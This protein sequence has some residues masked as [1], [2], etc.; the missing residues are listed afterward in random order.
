ML[1]FGLQHA[2]ADHQLGYLALG[3][4][5]ANRPEVRIELQPTSSTTTTTGP[6]TSTTMATTTTTMATTTTTTGPTPTTIPIAIDTYA[7]GASANSN[8]GTDTLLH[9]RRSATV[10]ENRVAY[11]RL[12]T[13]GVPEQ[14]RSN[15]PGCGSCA[16]TPPAPRRWSSSWP[17]R[18]PRGARPRS[19]EIPAPRRG[20]AR[21]L[22]GDLDG[23]RVKEVDVTAY[24]NAERAAA[25]RT[26]VSFCVQPP[27]SGQLVYVNSGEATTMRPE[28]LINQQPARLGR[29]R[30]TG[31]RA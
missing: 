4:A 29:S 19:K 12:D 6:T 31:R 17:W 5:T 18:R 21:L 26:A 8:F 25:G 10:G 7:N 28:L 9:T 22:H 24:V 13:A 27:T 23:A 3:E 1:S 11:L 15:P 30:G 2:V 14:S 16:A 20:G